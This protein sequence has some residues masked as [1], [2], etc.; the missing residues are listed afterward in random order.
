[1]ALAVLA[2][3][4]QHWKALQIT[5]SVLVFATLATCVVIPES[6]R[7]YIA[8]ER[9]ED[10]KKILDK[11]AKLNEKE[12]PRDI[13]FP[14]VQQSTEGKKYRIT[15]LFRDHFVISITMIMIINW[16]VTALCYYGLSLNAVNLAGTD[17]FLNFALTGFIEIPSYLFVA[18]T[19]DRIGRKPLLVFCQLL[20]G[21]GCLIAGLIDS[22]QA[23]AIT[24]LT[25]IGK[26]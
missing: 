9:F 24:A 11:G 1:M 15:A 26:F 10:A 5:L 4:I 3:L 7:W 2:L 14:K 21:V 17:P 16:M 13:D 22:N 20:A 23:A 25:L 18:G 8:H 12:L 19:I 6:P